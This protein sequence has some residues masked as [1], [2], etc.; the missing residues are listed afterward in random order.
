MPS[1]MN[2]RDAEQ[3]EGL[4]RAALGVKKKTDPPKKK[5]APVDTVRLKNDL[6]RDTDRLVR[7]SMES[8]SRSRVYK[9]LD[10]DAGTLDR[11]R[12]RQDTLE[13]ARHPARPKGR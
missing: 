12:A 9:T 6:E 4:A 7:T 10:V 2:P 13:T 1:A 5:A 8:P 3:F 11:V